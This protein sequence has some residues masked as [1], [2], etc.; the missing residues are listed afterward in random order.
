MGGPLYVPK[1]YENTSMN[2][3]NNFR[4]AQ[5]AD[6][7]LQFQNLRLGTNHS[8]EDWHDALR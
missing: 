8:P 7:F 4:K 5:L 3:L 1:V 6:V 2:F